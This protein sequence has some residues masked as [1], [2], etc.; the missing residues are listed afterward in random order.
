MLPFILILTASNSLIY[1]FFSSVREGRTKKSSVAIRA[2]MTTTNL[3]RDPEPYIRLSTAKG[4]PSP[5][6]FDHLMRNREFSLGEIM[7]TINL[8]Q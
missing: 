2:T 7:F 1:A 3:A 4:G 8:R 5:L 6:L